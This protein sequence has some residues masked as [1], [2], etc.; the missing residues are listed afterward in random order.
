M[1]TIWDIYGAIGLAAFAY[2]VYLFRKLKRRAKYKDSAN[3]AQEGEHG[4][5]HQ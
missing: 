5:G 2:T 4:K 1:I 3:G